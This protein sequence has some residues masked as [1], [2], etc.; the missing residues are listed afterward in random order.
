MKPP[1]F[2]LHPP[3]CGGTSVISFFNLNLGHDQFMHF[4]WSRH[5]WASERA[6]L[7][8]SGCGGGHHVFG[9][10]R[11]LRMP[12]RYCTILRD[13]LER[14]VSY[15]YYALNGKNGE[16]ERGASVSAVE[17]FIRRGLLSLDDWVMDSL[18][19]RNVFVNMISGLPPG[20][21]RALETAKHNLTHTIDTVGMCSDMSAFLLR[22]CARTD[23][24]LPFYV[25][26]NKTQSG[27]STEHTLGDAAKARFIADNRDD[28]ALLAHAKSLIEQ[29]QS[30]NDQFERALKQ[31]RAIQAEINRQ[32]NPFE[33]T[34]MIFGFD[35]RH[36]D[37]IREVIASH[38]L[39]PIRQYLDVQRRRSDHSADLYEG[40]IDSVDIHSARGWAVNL[41]RP[42]AI[43]DIEVW[44][45]DTIV[46]RGS[47]GEARPD[48]EGAGYAGASASGFTI[49]LPKHID[50]SSGLRIEIAHTP[51]RLQRAHTWRNG[52]HCA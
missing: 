6:R 2:F 43:V 9:M 29:A 16:V 20:D 10:H 38:D 52:W 45:G 8:Q 28:Y 19:G 51:E 5:G 35:Q 41:T 37:T 44:A 4:E 49:Q 22:L 50:M 42:E 26:S 24:E 40:F 1:I 47:T 23:L 25:E 7:L 15:F 13:P 36:L 30:G 14:Q 18:G 33:H 48:V 34:S 31:T 12:L 39:T 46:A 11:A 32:Q 27:P 17:A 3:K 21:E